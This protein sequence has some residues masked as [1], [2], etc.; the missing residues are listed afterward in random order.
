MLRRYHPL[1]VN[2]HFNHPVEL[3][4]AS[5]EA[6]R[7]L[8]DAGIPMGNQSVLLRGVNDDPKILEELFRGLVKTRVRPYYLYQCDLVRGVEHFRTPLSKGLSIMEYLRGRLS[9]VAIPNFVVDLP[10]GGGK[11]PLLPNYVIS[12]S[13]TH[14]VIRNFEGMLVSYPEPNMNAEHAAPSAPVE[15]P[16]VFDL[17]NGGATKIQPAATT[18]EGRRSARREAARERAPVTA[19]SIGDAG[20]AVA[21]NSVGGAARTRNGPCE[22]AQ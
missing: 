16:T 5:R 17:A 18:R 22:G 15:T 20:M 7:R 1:Y 10:H 6:C 19:A 12:M 2:T 13:P 4:P 21:G 11:I 9:G 3:T 8:V 14:T